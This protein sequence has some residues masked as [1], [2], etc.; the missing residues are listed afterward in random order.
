MKWCETCGKHA[1]DAD[2]ICPDPRC[3]GHLGSAPKE[4]VV[5]SHEEISAITKHVWKKIWKK[6][7]FLIFGEFSVLALIGLFGLLDIYE[8]ASNKVQSTIVTTI[9]NEFQTDRIHS[10]VSDVASNEAKV[11]LI[12]QVMPEVTNFEGQI[13]LRLAEINNT[14]NNVIFGLYSNMTFETFSGSD[15]NHVVKYRTDGNTSRILIRL[16]CV[17]IS[18]SIQANFTGGG[19]DI[20][21]SYKGP[22]YSFKNIFVW[23]INDY[24]AAASLFWVQYVKDVHDTN[25]IRQMITDGDNVFADGV[26]IKF[27]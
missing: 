25:I 24:N 15:S 12:A 18:G 1:D 14:A 21:Q 23:N 9:T 27:Q 4:K 11:L 17:P 8:K 3:R 16:S 20:P 26:P 6:H 5:V 7:L 13:G 19:L 22:I 2:I 10:T